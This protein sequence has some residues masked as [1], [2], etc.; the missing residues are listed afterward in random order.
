MYLFKQKTLLHGMQESRYATQ[1]DLCMPCYYDIE[2]EKYS[3]S[4]RGYYIFLCIL[5][6]AI[7]IFLTLD[8]TIGFHFGN[9]PIGL[10]TIFVLIFSLFFL[11]CLRTYFRDKKRY[12]EE[13]AKLKTN[14]ENFLK[15]LQSG[16][17]CPECGSKVE[18][19]ISVCPSCGYN[20]TS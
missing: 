19:G 20:I 12:P 5:A 1:H 15:T 9:T 14:K 11:L 18:I 10:F 8:L 17:V 2:M 6:G 13:F 4:P 3:F 16:N 7:L